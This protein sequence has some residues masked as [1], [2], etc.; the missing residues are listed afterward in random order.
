VPS[1]QGSG[2]SPS[3]LETLSRMEQQLDKAL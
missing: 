3:L 2:L 1:E